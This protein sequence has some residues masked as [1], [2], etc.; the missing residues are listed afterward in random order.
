M[1]L[2]VRHYHAHRAAFPPTATPAARPPWPPPWGSAERPS[3]RRDAAERL[4]ALSLSRAQEMFGLAPLTATATATAATIAAATAAAAD[5]LPKSTC[6]LRMPWA[7]AALNSQL[8]RVEVLLPPSA[9]AYI[10][11]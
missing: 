10:A 2:V 6:A 7:C 3:A 4:E 11:S 1:D 9:W 8:G 5:A